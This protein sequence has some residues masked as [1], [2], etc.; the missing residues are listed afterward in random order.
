MRIFPIRNLI[1]ISCS[2][3]N[4]HGP[5]YETSFSEGLLLACAE[6]SNTIR[7]F[8]VFLFWQTLRSEVGSERIQDRK[9]LW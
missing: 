1:K 9:K 7:T 4:I 5:E 2:N 3:G 8:V 6:V